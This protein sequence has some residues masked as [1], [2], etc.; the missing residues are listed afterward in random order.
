AT[1]LARQHDATLT[2]RERPVAVVPDRPQHAQVRHI[3]LP[4]LKAIVPQHGTAVAD[5][6]SIV[7]GG[8]RQGQERCRCGYGDRLPFAI[9]A[10]EGC[11]AL[12]H[13]HRVA[14]A[15]W[16]VHRVQSTAAVRRAPVAVLLDDRTPPTD[17]R[18][19][20]VG[21]RDRPE[22]LVQRCD[23]RLLP[24]KTIPLE[25]HP[26]ITHNDE[27]A[28]T[29]GLHVEEVLGRW[30]RG[31]FPGVAV[32]K[33]DLPLA[34]HR[35]ESTGTVCGYR[36]KCHAGRGWNLLPGATAV[37]AFENGAVLAHRDEIFLAR[38]RDPPHLG[39]NGR[40]G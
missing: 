18:A 29:V 34:T 20:A 11:T 25:D 23:N 22:V 36:E 1:A 2:H 10:L 32:A 14:T 31:E 24:G 17:D 26:A 5:R 37:I 16:N 38:S 19:L 12:P 33:Q 40:L 35:N 21:S 15:R 27:L 9:L 30:R 4:P 28:G 8:P 13:H 39:R 7:P 3:L 6:N